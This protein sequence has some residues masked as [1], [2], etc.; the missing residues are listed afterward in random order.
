MLINLIE[1]EYGKQL[2]INLSKEL[3]IELGKGFSRSNL[4]NLINI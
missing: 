2:L 3:S 1:G 4:I